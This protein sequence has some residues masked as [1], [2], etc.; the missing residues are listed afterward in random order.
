MGVRERYKVYQ[1]FPDVV[2]TTNVRSSVNQ[3]SKVRVEVMV[4]VRYDTVDAYFGPPS[5]GGRRVL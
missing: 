1:E 2:A 5:L 4:T 3:R